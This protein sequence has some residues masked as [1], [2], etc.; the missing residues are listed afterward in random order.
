MCKYFFTNG[1]KIFFEV[2]LTFLASPGKFSFEDDLIVLAISHEEKLP[3][4]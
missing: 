4:L 3:Y 1:K 2:S